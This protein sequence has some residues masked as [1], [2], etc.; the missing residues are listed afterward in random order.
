MVT[1]PYISQGLTESLREIG[2]ITTLCNGSR[3]LKG[4]LKVKMS[5]EYGHLRLRTDTGYVEVVGTFSLKVL[6]NP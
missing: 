2:Q 5:P 3:N 6:S 1:W 4:L